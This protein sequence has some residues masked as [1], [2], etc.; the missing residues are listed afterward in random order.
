M[1]LVLDSLRLIH[2]ASGASL[3]SELP[4]RDPDCDPGLFG[5]DSITWR[6]HREQ[7]LILA[8]ARS[9]LMQAAH[10]V[11]AHGALDHSRFAEDPFGRVY[12]TIH[13]MAVLLFGTTREANAMA[14]A[15]NQLHLTVRGTLPTAVGRYRVGAAYSAMD[16]PALLWV[17]VVFVDSMLTAYRSFVGPLS[18]AECEQYWQE[19][20]RYARRLGLTNDVLPASYG[21]MQAYLREVYPSG[22]VAVGAG[23]ETI[24]RM[25][26]HPALPGPRRPLWAVVR[27]M[28]VGQLPPEIRRQYGLSWTRGHAAMYWGACS[29]A[30]L[31]RRAF[32]RV[33]GQSSLVTLAERRVRGELF[34]APAPP[35]DPSRMSDPAVGPVTKHEETASLPR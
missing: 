7:W 15:L 21:A 27:L 10:P 8:G 32:P 12:R 26:L 33:L 16:P 34:Q 9:F 14:R 17:H 29:V 4:I 31:L 3:P 19:S 5:P 18:D 28:T 13:G 2:W 6:L 35:R 1:P 22:E 23:A 20:C 11:V 25:V 24:A 30:R